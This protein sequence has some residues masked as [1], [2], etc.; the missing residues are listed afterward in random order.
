MIQSWSLSIV[1]KALPYHG[2]M[3]SLES[4]VGIT[5]VIVGVTDLA[6]HFHHF[7]YSQYLF[8]NE[9]E[10][11]KLNQSGDKLSNLPSNYHPYDSI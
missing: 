2:V 7:R 4:G 5:K 8:N 10:C 1:K 11:L 3:P 6:R 9:Y